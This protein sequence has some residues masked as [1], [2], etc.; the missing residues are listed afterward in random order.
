MITRKSIAIFGFI[1]I[2]FK[3]FSQDKI[4]QV[5]TSVADNNKSMKAYD[6]YTQGRILEAKTGLLPDNPSITFDYLTG[7]NSNDHLKEFIAV[8]TF[9]FPSVYVH[10]KN[11]SR[12]EMELSM[13]NKQLYDWEILFQTNL[14]CID[15]IYL[16]KKQQ[17]LDL[18]ERIAEGLVE[19]QEK[20][21]ENGFGTIL[22]LDKA[23]LHLS[24]IR[25]EAS[26][27]Q[28]SRKAGLQHLAALNGGHIIEFNQDYY[29]G[30]Y[31]LP[32]F[33]SLFNYLESVDPVNKIIE[34][35]LEIA[36]RKVKLNR[37][38]SLPDFEAGYRY[39]ETALERFGGVHLG[40]TIPIWEN[41]NRVKHS[42][43]NV[44][45]VESKIIDHEN[46]HYNEYKELYNSAIS[47]GERLRALDEILSTMKYRENLEKA[48]NQ[49]EISRIEFFTEWSILYNTIDEYLLLEKEYYCLL[50]GLFKFELLKEINTN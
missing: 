3:G 23:R 35:E 26:K 21:I 42:K 33:D 10:R 48:L 4:Q 34:K 29:P 20:R 12:D 11:I 16:N 27:N 2:A 32:D 46:M 17:E 41:T 13:L 30:D 49:G 9:E 1:L 18:R 14:L 22:E 43:I 40:L 44:D 50:S 45:F 36:Q 38:N 24:T 6:N 5:I 7:G 8:Q 15:L 25:N 19:D 47:A 28:A 31:E 37:S 39:E